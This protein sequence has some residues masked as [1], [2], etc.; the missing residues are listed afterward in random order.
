MKRVLFQGDSITDCGRNRNDFY[1][2]GNGYA[3]LAKGDLELEFGEEYEVVNRGIGGNRITDLIAR[4]KVDFIN[5]KPDYLSILIGVNDIWHEIGNKNGVDTEDFEFYY[6]HL[7]T[8]LKEKLPETKIAIMEPYVFENA[9]TRNTEEV[10]N[11]WELF[12]T[13]VA[14]RAAVAKKLAEK[15]GLPF[16]PLQDELQKAVDRV[17]VN[18]ITA[19]GVHPQVAGHIVIKNQWMKWFKEAIK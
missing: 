9:S 12:K 11:R 14:E 7:L 3:Y 8:V 18:K 6:N 19:D 10:P 17:G 1:G 4:I 15:H 2:M 5:L 13:G 16:I